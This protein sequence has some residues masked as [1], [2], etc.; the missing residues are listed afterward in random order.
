MSRDHGWLT[1]LGFGLGY[2]L[3]GAALLL[4]EL[5]LVTMRW[6]FVLPLIVLAVGLALLGSGLFGAHRAVRTPREPTS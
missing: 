1:A 6:S 2:V 4:Q 3:A 5:D